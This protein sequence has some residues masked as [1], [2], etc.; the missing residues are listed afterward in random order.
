M[1][2]LEE[3][4]TL[5]NNMRTQQKNYFRYRGQDYLRESKKLEQQVDIAVGEILNINVKPATEPATGNL[6]LF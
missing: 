6:K 4:A 5:V 3:F 2:T 1:A